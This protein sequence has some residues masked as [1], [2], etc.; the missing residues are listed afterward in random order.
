ML[1]FTSD[2]E[3]TIAIIAII[4]LIIGILTLIF[5]PPFAI[6]C[7]EYQVLAHLVAI[8]ITH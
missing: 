2:A 7:I 5:I 3:L 1:T 4:L 8:H 6:L